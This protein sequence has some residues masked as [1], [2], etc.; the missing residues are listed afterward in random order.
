MRSTARDGNLSTGRSTQHLM[1]YLVGLP[2]LASCL[3]DGLAAGTHTRQVSI[4]Y[5]SLKAID[6][7]EKKIY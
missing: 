4:L 1:F 7:P 3:T 2:W 5:P 6:F